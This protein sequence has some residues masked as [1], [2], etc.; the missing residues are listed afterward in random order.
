MDERA[1]DEV[2]DFLRWGINMGSRLWANPHKKNKDVIRQKAIMV[3]CF[4]FI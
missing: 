2:N 4:L 1:D 3:L